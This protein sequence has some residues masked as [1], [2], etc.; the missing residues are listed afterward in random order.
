MMEKFSKETISYRKVVGSPKVLRD[1][2]FE[3]CYF[4]GGALA[5]HDDPTCGFVVKNVTVR[6][7]RVG[8][9]VLH[10]VRFQDVT[11][12]GLTYGSLLHVA[13][14]LFEKVTLRG[15]IGPMMTM[16]ANF[17]LPAQMQT[18]FLEQAVKFY[19]GIEW[20]LDISHAEFSDASFYHVPGHLVRRDPETQFLV[21]REAA[22]SAPRGSLPFEAAIVAERA[23]KSP[24]D[25][26]VWPVPTRSKHADAWRAG[27]Q[28]LRDRGIAE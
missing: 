27:M 18:A 21:H 28:V 16:P 26:I 3:R 13:A 7:C 22:L 17:T 5:Q 10:G 9:I 6:K 20:A 1:A 24:Y 8:S 12:D 15:R 23:G 4:E 19:A 11:V 25:T 14:C 2:E